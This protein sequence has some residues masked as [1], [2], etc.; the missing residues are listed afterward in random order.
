MLWQILASIAFL[1]LFLWGMVKLRELRETPT[2]GL[3]ND[4]AT[5]MLGMYYGLSSACLEYHRDKNRYPAV[6]RGAIDG[7]EELGYVKR[8]RVLQD[9]TLLHMF[10]LTI[11]ENSGYG[12]CLFKCSPRLVNDILDRARQVSGA[13][14]FM[15]FNMEEGKYSPLELPVKEEVNLVLPLPFKPSSS[16]R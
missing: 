12:I 10:A 6:M 16:R 9:S 7:L 14:R 13:V 4:E 11:T 8:Q 3:P 2:D 1:T 15:H 5:L